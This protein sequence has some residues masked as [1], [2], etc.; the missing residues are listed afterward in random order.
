MQC[1][2]AAIK[3]ISSYHTSL[4]S[5]RCDGGQTYVYNSSINYIYNSISSY[6]PLVNIFTHNLISYSSTLSLIIIFHLII[7]KEPLRA[8]SVNFSNRSFILT[9]F[10]ST[11]YSMIPPYP[12]HLIKI[13]IGS[14][15]GRYPAQFVMWV[16]SSHAKLGSNLMWLKWEL[17]GLNISNE[18]EMNCATFVRHV[19][20]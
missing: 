13:N 1:K 10:Y 18:C 8:T 17:E 19:W 20:V 14:I 5:P 2:L 3:Y 15:L 9:T 16:L 6:T 7:R 4:E 11:N 12:C